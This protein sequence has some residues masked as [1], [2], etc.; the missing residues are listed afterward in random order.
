[1]IGE[2]LLQMKRQLAR[3]VFTAWVRSACGL[4]MRTAENYMLAYTVAQIHPVLRDTKKFNLDALYQLGRIANSD[5]RR[6]ELREIFLNSPL[7]TP[8]AV[9]AEL[10]M[11]LAASDTSY[12]ALSAVADHTPS[13]SQDQQIEPSI[14]VELAGALGDRLSDLVDLVRDHG[15]IAVCDALIAFQRDFLENESLSSSTER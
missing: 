1:M 2:L 3:G 10:K 11:K 9:I 12:R 5:E 4:N 7:D 13:I 15:A 8:I 14:I 6:A